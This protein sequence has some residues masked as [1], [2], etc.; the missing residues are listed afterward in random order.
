MPNIMRLRFT[1][2]VTLRH[3]TSVP[4]GLANSGWEVENG[5]ALPVRVTHILLCP[6]RPSARQQSQQTYVDLSN[7]S[8]PQTSRTYHPT[9][10]S[11]HLQTV[12]NQIYSRIGS[13]AATNQHLDMAGISAAK[14]GCK[15]NSIKLELNHKMKRF[16]VSVT[17]R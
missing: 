6:V 12:R 7:N 16:P 15:D 2:F 5:I 10:K 8:T 1:K 17:A 13:A 14:K 4:D 3:C 11:R 9:S